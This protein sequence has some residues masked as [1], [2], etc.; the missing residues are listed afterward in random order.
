IAAGIRETFRGGAWSN[1]C[2]EWVSFD[3]VIDAV[4]RRFA[5]AACVSEHSHRGTH[6]GEER[7]LVCKEC[8]DGVMGHHSP[9][10][11][12]HL[13]GM[14]QLH[15]QKPW[16]HARP[17]ARKFISEAARSAIVQS[18]ARRLHPLV[19]RSAMLSDS[20][21]ADSHNRGCSIGGLRTGWAV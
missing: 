11:R 14:T 3:C 9:T 5:L 6:D 16:K 7:G 1:D 20:D 17:R 4:R 10:R 18:M 15:T 19:A 2:R 8:H 21:C 13:C 12:P